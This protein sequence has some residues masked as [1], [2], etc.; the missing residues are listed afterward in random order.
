MP[1]SAGAIPPDVPTIGELLSNEGYS[2]YFV[3]KW[4]AGYASWNNTPSGRGWE[5]FYGYLQGEEDYFTKEFCA[6]DA[7]FNHTNKCGSGAPT[8][9]RE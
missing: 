6:T 2:S 9:K 3:G 4:H 8:P 1:S 5:S 7:F